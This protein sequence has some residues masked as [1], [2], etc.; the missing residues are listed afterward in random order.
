MG[1]DDNQALL[2]QVRVKETILKI[3]AIGN[4]PYQEMDGGFS[5]SSKAIYND[6]TMA[7]INNSAISEFIFVIPARWLAGG[8][9][10]DTFRNEMRETPHIQNLIVFLNATHVFPMVDINGGICFLHYNKEYFSNPRNEFDIIPDD[11]LCIPIVRKVLKSGQRMMSEAMEARNT[12]GFISNHFKK[13]IS[14]GDIPVLCQGR[15][16]NYTS[17]DKINKNHHL[18]PLWKVCCPQA[19]GGSKSMRRQTLPRHQIFL[20]DNKTITTETYNVIFSSENKE[21]CENLIATLRTDFCIYLLC[22]RKVSQ[23]ISRKVWAWVPFMGTDKPWTNSELFSFF[24][25]TKQEQEH[26]HGM[27]ADWGFTQKAKSALRV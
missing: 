22:I 23:Q 4:P 24:D 5:K 14:Q 13:N 17:L 21:E 7:L 3:V 9:G 15:K 1:K 25:I 8:K 6:F 18:I 11:P 2:P 16:I 12:W 27:V 19:C 26:I 20:V 10:L